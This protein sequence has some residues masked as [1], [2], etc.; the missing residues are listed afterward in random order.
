MEKIDQNIKDK[1]KNLQLKNLIK[2]D[3]MT[4]DQASLNIYNVPFYKPKDIYLDQLNMQDN[5][6][7]YVNVNLATY[8]ENDKITVNKNKLNEIQFRKQQILLELER[9]RNG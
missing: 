2:L 8:V 3:A 4:S 1:S 9:L 7:I 5:R 6:Q